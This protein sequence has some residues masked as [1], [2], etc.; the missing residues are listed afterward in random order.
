MICSSLRTTALLLTGICLLVPCCLAAQVTT[1]RSSDLQGAVFLGA[2]NDWLYAAGAKVTLYGDT[3]IVSTV[4][5]QDGRFVFSNIGPP[6]IY[7]LQV[8]YLGLHAERNV[9]VDAG[10]V[11]QV[12]LGLE[13]PAPDKSRREPAS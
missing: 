3:G 8:N 1:N 12:S 11:L 13:A 10:A 7:F 4:T 9:T 2:P 5:D 6:G